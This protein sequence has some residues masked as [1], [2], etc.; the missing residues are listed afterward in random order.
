M[1]PIP[2]NPEYNTKYPVPSDMQQQIVN[3]HE[4]MKASELAVKLENEG[5][6]E[7]FF[8]GIYAREM[9]IPEGMLIVGR[10]FLKDHICTIS[11][12]LI[13]VW[14]KHGYRRI[15]APYTFT[16]EAGVNRVVYAIVE[17]VWTTYLVAEGDMQHTKDTFTTENIEGL[18]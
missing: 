7:Y 12:G 3:L 13:D 17:T 16:E 15:E 1:L 4:D 5:V 9:V 14:D 2:E 11:E 10:A 8:A 18:L 6:T